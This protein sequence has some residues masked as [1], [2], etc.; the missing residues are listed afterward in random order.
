[1]AELKGQKCS[2]CN[3]NKL[4]LR[5]DEVEIPHFGRVFVLSMECE[6]CGYRKADLEPAEEKDPCKY[7]FEVKSEDDLNV[8]VV[9]SSDATVKI[10]HVMT[11]ESG[12]AS[13]GYITNVEGLLNRV[14]QMIES[15][16]DGEDDETL[17]K[18]GK[19]LVKK[20]NK[21]LVG[22]EPLKIILED[23]TGHS[24]IISDKAQKS[25]L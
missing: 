10:P 24:A 7:T 6:A 21:V 3:E 23:P 22:R 1:M 25:K 12:P 5:E 15:S 4:V 17:K 14:K 13:D 18:K 9:K 19:N 8:K 11:I 2:F 16:V 20:L